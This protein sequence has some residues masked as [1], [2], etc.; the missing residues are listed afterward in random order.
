M[1][2]QKNN[3]RSLILHDGTAAPSP[4]HRLTV[5]NQALWLL[6][7]LVDPVD[8]LVVCGGGLGNRGKRPVHIHCGLGAGLNVGDSQIPGELLA[9]L[10]CHHTLG[11]EIGLVADQDL[12]NLLFGI[13]VDLL[14]PGLHRVERLEVRDIKDKDHRISVAPIARHNG[15][16]A[17]LPGR[18]PELKFCDLARVKD[19]VLDPEVNANG[20]DGGLSVGF[21]DI[22]PPKR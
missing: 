18:V 6:G 12:L 10:L 8:V 21:V 4:F 1:Y 2:T 16:E 3:P 15:L 13:L 14:S 5:R 20:G 22:L 7:S 11:G 9:H 19:N 17:L